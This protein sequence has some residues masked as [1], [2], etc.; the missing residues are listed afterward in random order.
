MF[1]SPTDV[2]LADDQVVQPD[3][4]IVCDNAK[5]RDDAIFGAPDVIF[6]VLSPATSKKDR[7]KKMKLYR[8]F[9]VSEYFLVDPDTEL[10]EKYLFIQERIGFA[11]S[12]DGDEVF[13]VD[14]IGQE[15]MAK[16]LFEF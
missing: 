16:D 7:N 13:L 12:Y 10:V 14:A 1:V 8:R 3:V 15:L 2:V 4:F 6:E 9:G 5:I 11:E